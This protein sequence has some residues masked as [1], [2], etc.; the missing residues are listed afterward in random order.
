MIMIPFDR[1]ECK[2]VN[3]IDAS[4]SGTTALVAKQSQYGMTLG[5]YDK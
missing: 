5:Y 2:K 3:H 1:L 4:A